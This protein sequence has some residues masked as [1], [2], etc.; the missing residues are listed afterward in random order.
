MPS[1]IGGKINF[2]PRLSIKYEYKIK[3]FRHAN[4]QKFYLSCTFSPEANGR[5]ISVTQKE[6]SKKR[7]WGAE[8]GQPNKERVLGLPE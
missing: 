1:T 4:F 6:K 3:N 5:F 2:I 8:A 7:A